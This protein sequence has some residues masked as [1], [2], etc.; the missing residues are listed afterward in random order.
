MAVPRLVRGVHKPHP[1]ARVPIETS[2]GD[3]F[4]VFHHMCAAEHRNLL[5]SC[6]TRVGS[7]MDSAHAMSQDGHRHLPSI[8]AISSAV[9]RAVTRSPALMSTKGRLRYR[10]AALWMIASFE[11]ALIVWQCVM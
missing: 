8:A 10:D 6:R 11:L 4:I 1:V 9:R 7:A 3:V 5:R 2:A